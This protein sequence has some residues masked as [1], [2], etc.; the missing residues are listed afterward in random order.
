MGQEAE[1]PVVVAK[2]QPAAVDKQVAVVEAANPVAAVVLV[3]VPQ[4]QEIM[5][6]R[7]INLRKVKDKA[8]RR[9]KVRAQDQKAALTDQVLVAAQVQEVELVQAVQEVVNNCALI[10]S[11]I[12]KPFLR[13]WLFL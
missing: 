10:T 1:Q 9:E 12:S 3:Q 2:Q 13:E 11:V 6:S 8:E 7:E 4:A 5:A